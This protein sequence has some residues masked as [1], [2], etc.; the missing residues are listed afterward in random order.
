MHSSQD[1]Y[2][3]APKFWTDCHGSFSRTQRPRIQSWG[4]AQ[5][6]RD[7]GEPV[8]LHDG[9]HHTLHIPAPRL[10]WSGRAPGR[11]RAV[12]WALGGA[13]H[14]SSLAIPPPKKQVNPA[15]W[16]WHRRRGMCTLA[17][18]FGAGGGCHKR[19]DVAIG[20]GRNRARPPHGGKSMQLGIGPIVG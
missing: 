1:H 7:T 18:W 14:S 11:V 13:F 6:R 17:G 10:T 3:H 20:E 5:D 19:A 9:P 15:Q 2:F 4:R 16:Q 12:V 8:T